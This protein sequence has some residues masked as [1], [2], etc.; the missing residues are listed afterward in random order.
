M[1]SSTILALSAFSLAL[2]STAAWADGAAPAPAASSV[3]G[4]VK[5]VYNM[6]ETHIV[7]RNPRPHV[8]ID[9]NRLVPRSPLPEL[10]QPLVERIG[11][12]VEKDPF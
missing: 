1:R 8:S 9:I 12:A 2:S 5:G 11:A 10:R 6:E 7:G 4:A 3:K